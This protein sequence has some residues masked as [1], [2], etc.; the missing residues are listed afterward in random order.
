MLNTMVLAW[1][2]YPR[3]NKSRVTFSIWLTSL[4]FTHMYVLL[5]VL[6]LGRKSSRVRMSSNVN[7]SIL[8]WLYVLQ[9]YI[10]V[11]FNPLPDFLI[12]FS[13]WH[14]FEFSI[15][16]VNS[17]LPINF[18]PGV[19]CHTLIKKW[20][21]SHQCQLLLKVESLIK[22]LCDIMLIK[23]PVNI[24]RNGMAS[25]LR[26]KLASV[27]LASACYHMLAGVACLFL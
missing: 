16:S 10:L 5:N 1:G 17:A 22:Y 24:C 6:E 4:K 15:T 27:W 21:N 19:P 14:L 23:G 12:I 7:A 11:S 25:F 18:F 9:G 2:R 20:P 8:A 13:N 3:Y 26:W